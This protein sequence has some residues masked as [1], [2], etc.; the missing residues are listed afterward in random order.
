MPTDLDMMLGNLVKK[1][2]IDKETGAVKFKKTFKT[3][4]T[5]SNIQNRTLLPLT[6]DIEQQIQRE[7]NRQAAHSRLRDR[8]VT[9]L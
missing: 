8:A 2:T 6:S 7:R 1:I 3:Q 5:R 4:V 9:V